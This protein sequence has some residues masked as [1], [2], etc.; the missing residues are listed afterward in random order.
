M[1]G[2]IQPVALDQKPF[3]GTSEISETSVFS[4]SEANASRC[5]ATPFKRPDPKTPPIFFPPAVKL[6]LPR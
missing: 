3:G 5:A 4:V 2:I 1:A 6:L